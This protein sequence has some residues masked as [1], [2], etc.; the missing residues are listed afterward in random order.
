MPSLSQPDNSTAGRAGGV[1]VLAILSM[2][3][4]FASISTD[5]YLPA[6]PLMSRALHAGPDRMALTLSGYL[7]GFGLSHAVGSDRRPNGLR[8]AA[9][10]PNA[11]S[12]PSVSCKRLRSR[13]QC[14]SAPSRS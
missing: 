13:V 8:M 11:P 9:S 4:A 3:M 6:M 1:R 7:I 5:M 10:G 14:L 12:Q 2:L